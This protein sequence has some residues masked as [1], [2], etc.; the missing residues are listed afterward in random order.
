MH[1]MSKVKQ[2]QSFLDKV[3]QQTG[4]FENSLLVALLNDRSITDDLPKG[5]ELTLS[6]V[7]NKRVVAFFNISNEPA[8]AVSKNNLVVDESLGIG[9]MAIGKTFII[10]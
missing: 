10:R 2:G 3:T 1:I 6:S 5:L 7:T 8:T 9:T 4:S